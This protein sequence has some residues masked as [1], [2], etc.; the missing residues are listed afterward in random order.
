[1]ARTPKP[2]KAKKNVPAPPAAKKS[3]QKAK[4]PPD[5]GHLKARLRAMLETAGVAAPDVAAWQVA[6]RTPRRAVFVNPQGETFAS[7]EKVKKSVGLG[8]TPTAA[9]YA[10]ARPL[11]EFELR[12]A[13]TIVAARAER[14]R[15]GSH[16]LS[17]RLEQAEIWGLVR[18][19]L[20]SWARA[21][22][23][24]RSD[25]TRPPRRVAG[26]AAI[27]PQAKTA[28]RLAAW[29]GD[30]DGAPA[31]AA[32]AAVAACATAVDATDLVRTAQR[33]AGDFSAF[34][35]AAR[36]QID[37][38]PSPKHLKLFAD[39]KLARCL[40]FERKARRSAAEL[41]AALAAAARLPAASLT[42][43]ALMAGARKR[44][45]LPPALGAVPDA[46]APDAAPAAGPPPDAPEEGP[47][48]LWL[49]CQSVVALLEAKLGKSFGNGNVPLRVLGQMS[50]TRNV[51]HRAPSET[52]RGATRH[53]A[54]DAAG[55]TGGGTQ[56]HG[57]VRAARVVQVRER[58]P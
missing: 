9:T 55:R 10:L 54:G 15:S 13:Q 35:G 7:M 6:M 40:D 52:R 57:H 37:R 30:A 16:N 31:A 25:G 23:G 44:V 56:V 3:R 58:A 46:V 21:R 8:D 24:R 20:R 34:V 53:V 43:E 50:D 12:G 47:P 19:D 26:D 14:A 45:C 32:A 27:R 42:A 48:D 1:M 4:P 49:L 33:V 29:D 17:R 11:R 51:R 28:E 39:V 41:A 36:F 18:E 2:R 22:R 5:L 38:N